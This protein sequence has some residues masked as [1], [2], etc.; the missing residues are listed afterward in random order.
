MKSKKPFK[1]HVLI[2]EYSGS[3]SLVPPEPVSLLLSIFFFYA[4][5]AV[6]SKGR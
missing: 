4:V 1:F 2:I 6:G 5:F 3:Q